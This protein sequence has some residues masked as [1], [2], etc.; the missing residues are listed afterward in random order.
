MS[1]EMEKKIKE[2]LKVRGV[3]SAIQE[4]ALP[5]VNDVINLFKK[6]D[7]NLKREE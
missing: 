5:S 2:S 4:M 1:I 3:C 6:V 7:I